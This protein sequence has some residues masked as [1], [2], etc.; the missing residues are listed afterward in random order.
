MFH[1]SLPPQFLDK[2]P[3]TYDEEQD[4]EDADDTG[5]YGGPGQALPV[6]RVTLEDYFPSPT[7]ILHEIQKELIEQTNKE[8]SNI[9]REKHQILHTL[10]QQHQPQPQQNAKPAGGLTSELTGSMTG[11]MMTRQSKP[12][13]AG[14]ITPVK[15]APPRPPRMKKPAPPPLQT[16][17][18][19]TTMPA[20]SNI[21][22]KNNPPVTL[23]L[24]VK[25]P[26]TSSTSSSNIPTMSNSNFHCKMKH[27]HHHG[28]HTPIETKSVG[29]GTVSK[30]L[31]KE[32]D[33]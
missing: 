8:N 22:T 32:A 12:A 25:K 23:Q 27:H 30:K 3:L 21:T 7:R 18:T 29:C 31:K 10:D 26:A 15:V 19:T 14:E 1:N 13:G 28:Q 5:D 17:T 6:Y 33:V 20:I 11:S 2:D 9:W 4:E 16:T 24:P